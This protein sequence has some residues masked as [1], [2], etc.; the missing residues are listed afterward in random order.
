MNYKEH[1]MTNQ[2]TDAIF[3]DFLIEDDND[4]EKRLYDEVTDFD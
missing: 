3:A 1:C 4:E 2:A